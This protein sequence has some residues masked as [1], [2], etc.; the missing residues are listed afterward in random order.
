LERHHCHHSHAAL[1][2]MTCLLTVEAWQLF[3]PP[4]VE[5]GL[6]LCYDLLTKIVPIFP[7]RINLFL[8]SFFRQDKHGM[9]FLKKSGC[10]W[11]VLKCFHTICLFGRI[12]IAAKYAHNS[13]YNITGPVSAKKHCALFFKNRH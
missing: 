4:P 3:Y 6:V 11:C 12:W 1:T 10:Y 5:V 13:Y 7:F 9:T 2:D 8:M